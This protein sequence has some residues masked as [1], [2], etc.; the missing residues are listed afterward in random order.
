ML[1]SPIGMKSVKQ[2]EDFSVYN[3]FYLCF[4]FKQWWLEWHWGGPH[5]GNWGRRGSAQS[6]EGSAPRSALDQVGTKGES[7]PPQHPHPKEKPHNIPSKCMQWS[8][9]HT[10]S[11]HN[12]TI[13]W[14]WPSDCI[15]MAPYY[16]GDNF[17]SSAWAAVLH[18]LFSHKING[19]GS[20]AE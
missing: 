18:T 14:L 17:L 20:S 4:N 19:F 3:L 10:N 13:W 1:G 5:L 16:P 7:K 2:N 9:T 11:V 15:S 12:S 8:H 6:W